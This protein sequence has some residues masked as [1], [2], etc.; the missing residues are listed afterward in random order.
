MYIIYV[1]GNHGAEMHRIMGPG[2]RSQDK[3]A[4]KRL[5][6][7]LLLACPFCPLC[8]EK[9]KCQQTIQ[10]AKRHLGKGAV[11]GSPRSRERG[12]PH[13]AR[14][15]KSTSLI[16][17]RRRH[18]GIPRR[19]STVWSAFT[20]PVRRWDL[21]NGATLSVDVASCE[22]WTRLCCIDTRWFS[23]W[24]RGEKGGSGEGSERVVER[25]NLQKP[26]STALGRKCKYTQR[27]VTLLFYLAPDS[28]MPIPKYIHVALIFPITQ[29]SSPLHPCQ[30][31][32]RLS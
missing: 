7:I 20:R 27:L 12:I 31:P 16:R 21:S 30:D 9:W 5:L 28:P 8:G 23:I 29:T 14:L 6:F 15:P 11:A 18:R 3:G 19:R 2:K 24:R 10:Q 1:G 17:G 22:R 13:S 26:F 32:A 4:R 25:T